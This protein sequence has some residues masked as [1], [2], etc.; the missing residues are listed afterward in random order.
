MNHKSKLCAWLL[1]LLSMGQ[2]IA[3]P[4]AAVPPIPSENQLAW[5]QREQYVFIHFGVN[6][7]TGKQWGYGDERPDI[8]NPTAFDASQWTKVVKD[9]GMKGI[10]L[11]CKHH[12]GFCLWQSAYTEHSV[13]NSPFR[14]GKGDVVREVADAC[15]RDGLFFGIYLSPWDRNYAQYGMPEYLTYYRSQLTELLTNYGDVAEVWFDGANGGDG[16]YGGKREMRKINN[17][18]YYDWKNTYSIVRQYAPHAL[19]FGD[20]GP[21]VR[22]CGN[23]RG[24]VGEPNWS[25][26]FADTLYAGQ[27]GINQ[28]LNNGSETGNAWMPAEVD[29]S[30]RPGWFYD[31][32]EDN[33]VRTADNLM[34]LYMESVG[35]G[36]NLLLNLPPDKRGLIHEKDAAALLAWKKMKD[37]IFASNLTKGA[38][39]SVSAYREKSARYAAG[40]LVDG[41]ADTYWATDDGVTSGFIEIDFGRKQ[42][43]SYVL[44]QEYIR[45]GQRVKAFNVE[46]WNGTAWVQ[47]AL[48]QTI[49]YKRIVPLGSTQ[50]TKLR[51]NIFSAKACPLISN[52]EVF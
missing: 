14:D 49:G 3:A 5:H 34:K 50:T 41:S 17:R 6:T 22:W 20:G 40:N 11:T 42:R 16:Y 39:V 26:I 46:A 8:F 35:R 25:P 45:L 52:V 4:P 47:L 12:D 2:A 15:R 23:E 51:I 13:K 7:F 9:A 18:T 32:Q 31:A 19:I 43:V 10:I 48:A 29:V 27:H 30:I 33:K 44:L 36:A 24:F 1:P 28:I 38:K 37:S 21:D